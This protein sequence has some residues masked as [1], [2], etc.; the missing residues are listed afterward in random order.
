M[1]NFR[2]LNVWQ[3]SKSLVVDIYYLTNKETFKR[4]FSLKDQMRRSAVSIPSNIAEGDERNSNKESIRFLYIANGSVAELITQ[5]TIAYEINYI[6]KKEYIA[7]LKELEDISK[8][9]KSLINYRSKN[10]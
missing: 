6:T 5:I 8:M 9:I 4:D 2:E 3:K 7:L 1:G 10:I